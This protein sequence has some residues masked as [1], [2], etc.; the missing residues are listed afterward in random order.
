MSLSP[1][2]Q[3]T[4][5]IA[6][7]AR[8]MRDDI[9]MATAA[10][11]YMFDNVRPVNGGSQIKEQIFYQLSANASNFAGGV[12]PVDANFV[13]NA[14]EAT[15]P[16]VYYWYSV[17]IPDTLKILN[18]GE[19]EVI[20]LFNGQFQGT[21]AS[22]IQLLGG[23]IWGTGANRNGAPTLSGIA[24]ASTYS[25]DSAGGAYGGISRTGSSGTFRAPVGNAVF[26][27]AVVL[28]INGGAQTTWKAVV[29]TGLSTSITNQAMTA[30]TSACTVGK[31]RPNCFLGDTTAWNSFHNIIVQTTLQAPLQVE[32]GA[33]YPT[34]SFAGIPV[35]Q[36]DYAP[37]GT[38][39]AL[40]GLYELRPWTDGFFVQLEPVRPYNAFATI[41]Y[42]LIV[43]NMVNT[44]PNTIGLMSGILS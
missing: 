20:N 8:K 44:R 25:A 41:Y 13:N 21:F 24:A 7:Y 35:I 34:I 27:N 18:Q 23:D 10:W 32:G 42:G 43:M 11:E 37:V 12:A 22:L 9:T 30:F 16:P 29:D 28:L 33:G 40:N 26:W 38:L 2:T 39:A 4:Q 15:F 36:D 31:Y 19:G 6:N 14:T 17:M 1:N 5:I 3:N